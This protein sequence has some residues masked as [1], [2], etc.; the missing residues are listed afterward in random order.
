MMFWLNQFELISRAYWVVSQ[1]S[2]PA[3]RDRFPGGEDMNLFFNGFE[4]SNKEKMVRQQEQRF[5]SEM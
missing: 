5:Y 2:S 4:G 3:K 1:S